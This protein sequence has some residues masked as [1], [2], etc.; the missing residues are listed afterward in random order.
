MDEERQRLLEWLVL[1]CAIGNTAFRDKI[2]KELLERSFTCR[3]ARD[4]F[5]AIVAC[6]LK[7]KLNDLA[8][9]KDN[10]LAVILAR[11]REFGLRQE[12]KHAADQLRMAEP[13]MTAE[14]WQAFAERLLGELS[15]KVR[16]DVTNGDGQ[17][18]N[19]Q[20]DD[21][22]HHGTGG[23]GEKDQDAGRSGGHGP[24]RP[25][26]GKPDAGRGGPGHPLPG[27]QV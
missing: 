21:R 2:S 27:R 19:R 11:L 20:G 10:G 4:V 23:A 8:G 6:T 3:R 9:V 24:D 13:G 25:H 22:K 5:K 1:G 18:T 7:E 16:K 17:S 12:Q 14:K 26:H 15:S